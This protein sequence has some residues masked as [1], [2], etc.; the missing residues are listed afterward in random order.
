MPVLVACCGLAATVALG[1]WTA[2]RSHVRA[3]DQERTQTAAALEQAKLQIQDL[4]NRLKTLAEKSVETPAPAPAPPAPRTAS[5]ASRKKL[6]RTVPVP[7][8]P[9]LDR[10]QGQLTETQKELATTHE[11]LASAREQSGKDKEELDGKIT[12][13]RDELNGSIASTHDEVVA[14][15]KRG[16]QNVYEFKLTKSKEMHRGATSQH[17]VTWRQCETQDL[18]PGDDGGR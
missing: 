15:Q 10:L 14:L 2:E 4:G 17:L 9:R 8:D 5:A 1:L 3:L 16:E 6:V 7:V 18:R 12:S 13:T 11:E